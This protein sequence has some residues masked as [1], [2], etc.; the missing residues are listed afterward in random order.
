MQ[1]FMNITLLLCCGLLWNVNVSAQDALASAEKQDCKVA[2]THCKSAS[3]ATSTKSACRPATS[4]AAMA[5]SSVQDE[6]ISSTAY[7]KANLDALFNASYV[8][9]L[10]NQ[11]SVPNCKPANCKPADC[12]PVN[13]DPADCK[14]ANCDPAD[15]SPA[16][17]RACDSAGSK[18][19]SVKGTH[20]SL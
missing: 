12:K 1:R 16:C 18:A 11:P 10:G 9:L 17:K 4:T 3:T 2:S 14:P 5:E 13:C 7:A 20:R 6:D 19:A 8:A 15:C